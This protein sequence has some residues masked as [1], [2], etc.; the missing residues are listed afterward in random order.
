M[1]MTMMM[2]M[3]MTFNNQIE[4]SRGG[5]DMCTIDKAKDND[6]NGFDNEIKRQNKGDDDN[7]NGKDTN[8]NT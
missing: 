7:C 8:Y 2:T 3:T 1:T 4:R 5:G 6:N